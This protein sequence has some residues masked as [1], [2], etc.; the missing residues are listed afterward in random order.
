H[1]HGH[2]GI[3]WIHHHEKQKGKVQEPKG[4][5]AAFDRYG[6]DV[7]VTRSRVSRVGMYDYDIVPQMPSMVLDE[8]QKRFRSYDRG[9]L[10]RIYRE[11]DRL[12]LRKNVVDFDT[13]VTEVDRLVR[14]EG[15][16]ERVT[17]KTVVS[18]SPVCDDVERKVD[19]ILANRNT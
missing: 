13:V 8:P 4:K 19:A 9:E 11:V 18:P 5:K 16:K 14:M 10:S 3:H 7:P 12:L 17:E 2:H 1:T 6:D 15:G